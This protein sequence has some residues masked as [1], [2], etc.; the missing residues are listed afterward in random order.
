MVSCVGH[1]CRGPFSLFSSLYSTFYLY[2]LLAKVPVRCTG[3][4]KYLNSQLVIPQ[5]SNDGEVI[6][7][8]SCGLPVCILERLFVIG[9]SPNGCSSMPT[10]FSI[11][12]MSR[13]KW[14]YPVKSCKVNMC[15]NI[16][17]HILFDYSSYIL[18]ILRLSFIWFFQSMLTSLRLQSC[19][20]ECPEEKHDK[21]IKRLYIPK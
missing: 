5:T 20:Y 19:V 2:E 4:K 14:P 6:R 15:V 13:T 11:V 3:R 10:F 21:V 1:M 8:S 18:K 17:L 16:N 12:V 7:S 9:S